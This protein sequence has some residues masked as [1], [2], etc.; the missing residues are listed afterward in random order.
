M[1]RI[2]RRVKSDLAEIISYI[3]INPRKTAV[4][5]V[6]AVILLS[7]LLGKNVGNDNVELETKS[8]PSVKVSTVATLANNEGD[9]ILTGEV[10]NI[11]QSEL[12]AEKSGK[13]TNVYVTP[14]QYVT[15]GSILAE[16]DNASERATVLSAQG[17]LE[18][19]KA[20][21]EKI[22]NG[23]RDEDKLSATAQAKS[24]I[25][26]LQSTQENARSV[27]SSAYSTAQN[28]IL[29]QTDNYFSNP[30]TVDPSFRIKSANY[31]E[32]QALEKKRVFIT[33]VLYKW[34]KNTEKNIQPTE[35]KT[36][37]TK[38]ESDLSYIK[39]F[40]NEIS[41][42]ISKQKLTNDF[43]AS[44]KN[45]QESA[46]LATL[47]SVDSARASISNVQTALANASSAQTITSLNENKILVGARS[48][49]VDIAKARVTQAEGALR[50]AYAMLERSIIR[51]PISGIV[52]TLN[53][54]KGDYINMQKSVAVVVG[55]DDLEIETFVTENA[56]KQISIGDKAIIENTY[57]GTVSTIAP[58]LDPISKK[59]RVTISVPKTPNII[60]GSYV[61]IKIV[62]NKENNTDKISKGGFAIPITAVKVTPSGLAVFTVSKDGKLKLHTIQEG[63]IVGENMFVKSGLTPDLQIVTDARGLTENEKVR[64][65]NNQ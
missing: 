28:A 30:Y 38:A 39:T 63:P 7:L 9:I 41:F 31:D 62:K 15:A 4:G 34:K 42:F 56:L 53:I 48:E 29:S 49:D 6:F 23:A 35:L 40:L 60:N 64:I 21:L 51:T 13:I 33:S 61:E 24:G 5:V 26:T 2:K 16:I 58:G 8:I 55:D 12:R 46:M 1:N 27:Y 57:E 59:A 19:A 65:I 22:K 50:S 10:K 36:L 44:S 43:T 37:L 47:L 45:A 3:K 25:I 20:N 17:S 18:I 32:R 54:S 52:S 14:G 11:S